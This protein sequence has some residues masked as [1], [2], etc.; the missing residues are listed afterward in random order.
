MSTNEIIQQI[1]DDIVEMCS[2]FQVF[3]VSKKSNSKGILTAFKVCIIVADTYI[4]HRELE[5]E[6][7]INTDCPVPCDII[8]YNISEWNDCLL[9]DCTFAYR[10]DNEGEILYEQK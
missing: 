4:N 1:T 2:P 7:L 9:D 5:S 3:L 8:V 10:I 6:I